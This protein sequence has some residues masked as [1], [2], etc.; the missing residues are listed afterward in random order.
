MKALWETEEA[1]ADPGCDALC[2]SEQ[3]SL[4]GEQLY[5]DLAVILHPHVCFRMEH[6]SLTL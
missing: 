3:G 5:S 2:L 6:P 4:L 1:L